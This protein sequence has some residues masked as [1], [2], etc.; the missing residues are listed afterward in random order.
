MAEVKGWARPFD[1]P[2]RR[3]DGRMLR[4][5]RDAGE[6][7]AAL[8]ETEHEAPAWQAALEALL[9][10]VERD[11]LTMMARIG[12]MRAINGGK[13]DPQVT[14]RPKRAKAYRIVG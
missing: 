13:P 8:P 14:P 11:G 6:Y 3:D 12:M 5:L 10:V 4:T 2:I 1:D 9:L 7:I